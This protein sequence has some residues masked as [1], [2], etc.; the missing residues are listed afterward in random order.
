[1]ILF[2]DDTRRQRSSLRVTT[3]AVAL[4]ALAGCQNAFD[5]DLRNPVNGLSTTEAARQASLS[6]PEPDARGV[7]SYPTYQVAIARRGDT[8]AS[9]AQRVG[10]PAADLANHNGL[11]PDTTLRA[12]E[13]LALPTRVAAAPNGG[14]P[15]DRIDI[16]TLAGGA[17][18]RAEAG[19]T[20]SAAQP[21]PAA[22]SRE[23][24]RHRVQRGE[25]AFTIARLYNVTPRA[26]ADWNGLGPDMMIREGQ[27][28]LIPLADQSAPVR[29]AAVPS[30]GQGS[31]TP[32]PPS[33]AQPLPQTSSAE[34]AAAPSSPN[35]GAQRTAAT[36]PA[37]F[38]MP[39]QGSIIRGYQRGQNE[40]IN[41]GATA[42]APVT[43]AAAGTVARVMR[44]TS[45]VQIVLVRH[46][47]NVFSIYAN[48]ADIR[49]EQGA[50]VTRGQR[51]ASVAA[52]EPSFLHFEIREGIES[53]DP[54][55]YLQ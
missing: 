10:I 39:V 9:I 2:P 52:G 47:G 35:L 4:L 3:A 48:V 54:M 16:T 17:I 5:W 50:A 34:T 41:I 30:P 14:A 6:R 11:T 1:M 37:R 19:R 12:D 7:L 8:V 25:T 20:G 26:L 40:N 51:I 29:T 36:S 15:G 33:A 21:Q 27:Y 46:E 31:A 45:G 53:V 28:L 42:G 49:V 18:D 44:D 43:A 23:P 55:N 24:S 32:A 38:A 22:E 13:V